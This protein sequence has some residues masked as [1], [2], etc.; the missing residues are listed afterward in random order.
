MF[1]SRK[2]KIDST[3]KK[4]ETFLNSIDEV[5]QIRLRG[6][7]MSF[8]LFKERLKNEGLELSEIDCR[9]TDFII[10]RTQKGYV[11]VD[12]TSIDQEKLRHY[13]EGLKIYEKYKDGFDRIHEYLLEKEEIMNGKYQS[14][15]IDRNVLYQMA[16]DL[17]Y[18]EER[19]KVLNDN[20][21]SK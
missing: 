14:K 12:E 13:K 18:R 1:F 19:T 3:T 4:Y 15:K 10:K 5:S 20:S 8:N 11:P 16:L 21:S 2:K 9:G 17:G 7:D 6:F